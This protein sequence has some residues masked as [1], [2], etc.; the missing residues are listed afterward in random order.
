MVMGL[1]PRSSVFLLLRRRVS[2]GVECLGHAGGISDQIFSDVMALP[3]L[4]HL[5]YSVV[6]SIEAPNEHRQRPRRTP[7]DGFDF[8]LCPF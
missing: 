2:D 8:S 6:V 3:A 7:G 5:V 1:A 4:Y